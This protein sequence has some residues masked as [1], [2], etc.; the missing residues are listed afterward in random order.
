MAIRRLSE[1][2]VSRIAAGEVIDRPASV[3]KELI[4]NALDAGSTDIDVRIMDGGRRQIV[5]ADDGCGMDRES[6]LLAVE[7]HA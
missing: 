3:V 5:V 1:A 4:E 7:R 6:L 2:T